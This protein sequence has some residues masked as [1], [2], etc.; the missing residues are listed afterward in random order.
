MKKLVI[1]A[2]FLL[3]STS[4]LHALELGQNVFLKDFETFSGSSNDIDYFDYYFEGFALAN[5]SAACTF[6]SVF[7]VMGT[8]DLGGGT[9]TLDADLHLNNVT[10]FQSDGT[11]IGNGHKLVLC[12]SITALT[13][14]LE[15]EDVVLILHGDIDV[16]GQITVSGNC[17]IAGNQWHIGLEN[18]SIV[19]AA[20]SQ[21]TFDGVII[22]NIED[23]KLTCT[24]DTGLIILDDTVCVLDGN[25]TFVEGALEIQDYVDFRGTYTFIYDS[26]M[27]ATINRVSQLCFKDEATLHVGNYT[28]T[29]AT[30][31]VLFTDA[32][33]VLRFDNGRLIGK[34][35]G[36]PLKKGILALAGSSLLS[37]EGATDD[38]GIIIGSGVE[39]DD[40]TIQ[41]HSGADVHVSEGH[42]TYNNVAADK[43]V[44]DHDHALITVDT[45]ATLHAALD[46]NVPEM[47]IAVEGTERHPFVSENSAVIRYQKAL[48]EDESGTFFLTG[49]QDGTAIGLEGDDTITL[50]SGALAFDVNVSGTNNKINGAGDMQGL[51]TCADSSTVLK[52]DIDG[53]FADNI[54]LQGARVELDN[55][56]HLGPEVRFEGSGTVDIGF[57]TVAVCLPNTVWTDTLTIETAGGIISLLANT[58]IGGT[59]EI[60]GTCTIE[61]NGNNLFFQ[62]GTILVKSGSTLRLHDIRLLDMTNTAIQCE[63]DTCQIILDG[64]LWVQDE[65]ITFDTGS[66]VFRNWVDFSGNATFFYESSETSTIDVKS[67][68]KISDGLTLE[69]GRRPSSS[70]EPLAFAARS[71]SLTFDN[72]VFAVS[73][74][75]INLT[76]G[77]VKYLRDVEINVHSTSLAN[78]LIMGTGVVD[79]DFVFEF[80]PGAVV[81]LTAGHLTYNVTPATQGFH[82][83]STTAQLQRK[84]GTVFYVQQDLY[85]DSI[86]I[87]TEALSSLVVEPGKELTYTNIFFSISVGSY[88]LTGA[89]QTLGSILLRGGDQIFLQQG[90]FPATAVVSGQQNSIQGNG[91]FAGQVVYTASDVQLTW[92]LNGTMRQNILLN[93]GS[94]TLGNHLNF[95]GGAQLV[96]PGTVTLGGYKVDAGLQETTWSTDIDWVST[97]GSVV[98]NANLN[99]ESTWTFDGATIING[100]GYTLDLGS[101][102]ELVVTEGST[103]HLHDI[104]I[105]NVSASN[106]RCLDD[107]GVLILDQVT[108]IL[109]DDYTLSNGLLEFN[110]D[111]VIKGNAVFSYETSQGATIHKNS[112]LLFDQGTTLRY[113]PQV[114]PSA[115]LWSFE[116]SSSIL[117]MRNSTLHAGLSGM[118]LTNGMLEIYGTTI[119]ESEVDVI[120]PETEEEEEIFI[121]EGITLGDDMGNDMICIV[122]IGATLSIGF[123]SLLNYR[124]TTEASWVSLDEASSMLL[125]DFSR[126]YL[127]QTL[128]VGEG[129]V[130]IYDDVTV[131]RATGALLLGTVNVIGSVIFTNL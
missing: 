20:N 79:D 100:N 68:W 128:N 29:P 53:V 127:Y 115:T 97:A 107:A 104:I 80:F 35:T 13:G 84:A 124:N 38:K 2:L 21:V 73:E 65:D 62:S 11:I 98:M 32:T 6:E 42:L 40:H 49:V 91:A 4:M 63:D 57:H 67:E 129:Q 118:V 51:I 22:D 131:G 123:N 112:R 14:P 119:F 110:N 78:G 17:I 72:A 87:A 10:S 70:I 103:L 45:Q 81:S 114:T 1:G 3:M 120:E 77:T 46:L 27:P 109:S 95:I 105:T 58:T 116:D 71:S 76:K 86:N 41:L 101:T 43:V 130:T 30:D 19:V 94:L 106:I 69:I 121:D 125:D 96:G 64:V 75:G 90:L 99:L 39:A 111:V 5:D 23:G 89:F 8:V 93:G 48:M 83:H 15:I 117:M 9:L 25:V 85:L 108:L 7:P 59:W 24:D 26:E 34:D 61:G 92:M 54:V 36:L 113:D 82:S 12:S 50:V 16:T 31:P 56:I 122:D 37:S 126:L 66:L 52:I 88:L 74:E 33:S 18:G 60:D 28:D 47:R 44:A 102:G 55:D